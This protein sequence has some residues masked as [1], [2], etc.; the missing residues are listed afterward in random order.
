MEPYCCRKRPVVRIQVSD[1]W[2]QMLVFSDTENGCTQGSFLK[3]MHVMVFLGTDVRMIRKAILTD[4]RN[5]LLGNV[6][7]QGMG[8]IQDVRNLHPGC[9][10][11]L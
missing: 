9:G 1:V 4:A 11:P 10:R 7:V 5:A 2:I 6:C 3:R 8:Q